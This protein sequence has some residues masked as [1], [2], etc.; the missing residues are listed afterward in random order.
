MAS[1]LSYT[2]AFN[3]SGPVSGDGFSGT[4]TVN[5][6]LSAL[7][8]VDAG[9]NVS[10]TWTY[11]GSGSADGT[12]ILGPFSEPLSGSDTGT[13]SGTIGNVTFTSGSGVFVNGHGSFSANGKNF[14]GT[15]SA[16]T[17]SFSIA[18]S[19]SMAALPPVVTFHDASLQVDEGAGTVL[20][21]LTRSFAS[22]VYTKVHVSS[23]ETLSAT[24]GSDFTA[25]DM[26][27]TFAPDELS[28]TVALTINDDSAIEANELI[29][30]RVTPVSFAGGGIGGSTTG[31]TIL[32]NDSGGGPTDG[33]DNLVGTPGDD[34][35]NGSGGDDTISGGGGNDRLLG[36]AGNDVLK[37][38]AG[39]DILTGGAG[40]DRI[41]G[42]AGNDKLT[43]G[44]GADKFYFDSA[45]NATTNKDQILDFSSAEKDKIVL[46]DSVFTAFAGR[47]TVAQSQIST[48]GTPDAN[49]LLRYDPATGV[50]YY[51]SNGTAN[52]H[53]WVAFAVISQDGSHPAL[54]NTDF[55]IVH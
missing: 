48:D 43:G 10:G 52:G 55:Q 41:Y 28:K 46:N 12:S 14:T 47:T 36:G 54:H 23:A 51:D 22:N 49:D 24:A 3:A 20:V 11:S 35:I 1:P 30:L 31:V 33:P 15:A 5:G 16:H 39:N 25:I 45:L 50:L 4:A 40:N 7:V 9:G 13:L 53:S 6:T 19:G 8:S 38:G 34:N 17:S 29:T 26:D 21:T 37:G 44:T 27:V 18:A 2:G 32:D 42:G